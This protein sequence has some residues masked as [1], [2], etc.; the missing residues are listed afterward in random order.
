M[1]TRLMSLPS[2][3]LG[4]IGPWEFAVIL[5]IGLL[6][7]GKKLPDV[8]RQV[9]RGVVEF[10]RNLN[11]LKRQVTEDPA[12]RDARHAL[13]DLRRDIDAPQQVLQTMR[14]PVRMFDRLTH[15]DLATPGPSAQHEPRPAGSFLEVEPDR[16]GV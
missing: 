3:F 14:D 6:L 7:F 8:G 9:G 4:P 12:L 16:R 13:Q 2:A 15:E 5:M 1:L 10:K 11:Q